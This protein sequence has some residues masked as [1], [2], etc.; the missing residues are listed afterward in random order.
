M[1]D[2]TALVVIGA[3]PNGLKISGY[4]FYV[5]PLFRR[6][7]GQSACGVEPGRS[8]LSADIMSSKI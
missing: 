6:T 1:Q 4:R 3:A 2:A 7:S 8:I 5:M